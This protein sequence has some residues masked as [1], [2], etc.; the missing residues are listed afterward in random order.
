MYQA[1]WIE[2]EDALNEFCKKVLKDT[3][4][5][6]ETIG[7][8]DCATIWA[9]YK[10]DNTTGEYHQFFLVFM[11]HSRGDLTFDQVQQKAL[12]SYEQITAHRTTVRKPR[13]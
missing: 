11:Q 5:F 13:R 10:R 4:H 3:P 6:I 12:Q 9:K 1:I 2:G 8:C 7:H